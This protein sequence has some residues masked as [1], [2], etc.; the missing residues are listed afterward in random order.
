MRYLFDCQTFVESWEYLKGD[1]PLAETLEKSAVPPKLCVLL[2]VDHKRK[3]NQADVKRLLP[4]LEKW[5]YGKVINVEDPKKREMIQTLK[6]L[7]NLT[8][9]SYKVPSKFKVI[10]P[11]LRTDRLPRAKEENVESI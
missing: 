1:L 4:L 6:D 7:Q 11:E 10:L 9:G 2:T 5:G 8:E 3:G